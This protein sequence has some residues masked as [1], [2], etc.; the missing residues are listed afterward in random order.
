VRWTIAVGY[1]LYRDKFKFALK[2]GSRLRRSR[3]VLSAN[4]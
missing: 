4:N 1:Y 2:D 3:T